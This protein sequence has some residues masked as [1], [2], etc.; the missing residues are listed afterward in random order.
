MNL[1]CSHDIIYQCY[2]YYCHGSSCLS[3]NKISRD[4]PRDIL[5]LITLHALYI[6]LFVPFDLEA[7]ILSCFVRLSS[8]PNLWLRPGS[9]PR[10]G[11]GSAGCQV[12]HVNN[13]YHTMTATGARC[14]AGWSIQL[15]IVTPSCATWLARDWLA[16]QAAPPTW[17]IK[18]SLF[19]RHI[20]Y[21]GMYMHAYIYR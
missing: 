12:F 6:P 11:E 10:D 17:G 4:A 19:R 15:T 7:I 8:R 13:R 14:Q 9:P 1:H 16:A 20:L 5:H 2:Y 21:A 18:G 3:E